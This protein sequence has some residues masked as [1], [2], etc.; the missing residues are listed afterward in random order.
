MYRMKGVGGGGGG[1]PKVKGN[2]GVQNERASERVASA[3]IFG[4]ALDI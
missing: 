2:G 1:G 4:L 3:K